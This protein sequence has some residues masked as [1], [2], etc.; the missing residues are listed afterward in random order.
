MKHNIG[1]RIK[2]TGDGEFPDG[3]KGQIQIPPERVI[4]LVPNGE[5]IGPERN[6][7]TPN[8]KHRSYWVEFDQPTDD[9]SGDG[10]YNG[11]E[12]SVDHIQIL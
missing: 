1:D 3:T 4:T 8:G 2:I 5:W 7:V 11:A 9:G 12:I 6:F 10:P